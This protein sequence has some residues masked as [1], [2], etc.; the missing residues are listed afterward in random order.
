MG[1][2]NKSTKKTIKSKKNNDARQD[3]GNKNSNQNISEFEE[4]DIVVIDRDQED[5]AIEQFQK[6]G[7]LKILEEVY[8]QRISTIRSWANKHYYPGLTYSV[9]DLFEDLSVVFVKAA[10]KYD[11]SRGPFNTC[12]FTFLLN[13]LKNIKHSK[14]AKKRLPEEY[15]GPAIGMILSLDYPYNANDGSEVTLKDVIPANDPTETDYVLANTYMEETLNVLSQNDPAFRDFLVR[16][17]E[18]SSLISLI[19]EYK[20]R[21]GIVKISKSQAE[22]FSSRK[23]NRMVSDLIRD[24]VD[25]DFTLLGYEVEGTN[26]LKYKVELKKTKETDRFIKSLKELRNNKEVYKKR[27]EIVT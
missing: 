25:G 20:T 27:L 4:K 19:R 26:R 2:V 16:L 10:E 8:K 24:K 9:D 15:E 12:L 6:T 1:K 22:R 13:R 14:H 3:T 7:D 11:K 17:G 5:A 21:K 18:G 23:C